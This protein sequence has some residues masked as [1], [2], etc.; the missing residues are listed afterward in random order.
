MFRYIKAGMQVKL[1]MPSWHAALSKSLAASDFAM[2]MAFAQ[3]AA[4]GE[5]ATHKLSSKHCQA[6]RMILQAALYDSYSVRNAF[7]APW[8]ASHVKR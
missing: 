7:N 5:R 2:Y 1:H 6:M 4:L 8:V 3:M